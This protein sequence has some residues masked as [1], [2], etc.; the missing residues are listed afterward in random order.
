[1][2]HERRGRMEGWEM[3]EGG[4]LNISACEESD[5]YLRCSRED[6]LDWIGWDLEWNLLIGRLEVS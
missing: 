5:L 2:G 1:M 4:Q 6:E 3:S